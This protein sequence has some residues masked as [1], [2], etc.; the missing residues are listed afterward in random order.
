MFI[1]QC[2]YHEFIGG[3]HEFIGGYHDKR[4]GRSLVKQLNLYENPGVLNILWR[5]HDILSH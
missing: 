2:G 1:T 5:A 3:Y 4:R